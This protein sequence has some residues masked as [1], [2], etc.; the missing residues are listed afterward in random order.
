MRVED[1]PDYDY[2]KWIAKS[3]RDVVAQARAALGDVDAVINWPQQ[4]R[5][6]LPLPAPAGAVQRRRQLNHADGASLADP[7]HQS[8]RQTAARKS[9]APSSSSPES[10]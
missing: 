6:Q 8:A 3:Y 1:Q 7:G 4:S 10:M 9:A 5:Q 2:G